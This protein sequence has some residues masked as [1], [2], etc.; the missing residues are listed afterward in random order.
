MT[1]TFT[2]HAR[3]RMTERK[4]SMAEVYRVFAFG[5]PFQGR[6]STTWRVNS[7]SKCD[8]HWAEVLP[9][10]RVVCDDGFKVLTVYRYSAQP[11]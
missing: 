11:V 7:V 8:G 5:K 10:L 9:P 6:M 2:K 3:E 4:I 1:V